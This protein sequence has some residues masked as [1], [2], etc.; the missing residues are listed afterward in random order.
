V[1]HLW[2][3]SVLAYALMPK[4]IV[5]PQYNSPLQFMQYRI[6][7]FI[8]IL[9]C[10]MVSGGAHGQSFTRVSG[11]LACLFFTMTYLDARSLNRVEADLAVVVSNLPPNSRVAAA[12][13]DSATWRLDGLGHVSSIACL[14][15]CFDYGNYEASTAQFRVRVSGP[16]GVV[17]SDTATVT[18]IGSGE[19][20][21]TPQEAP[22][23]TVCAS[24]Q[25]DAQ[26]HVL[27]ELRKLAAGE[28]TCKVRLPA[29]HRF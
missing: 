4:V 11:L 5:L 19:H 20:I 21:V 28:T 10:A 18:E 17:A 9:L 24:K 1:V 14:G 13:N 8:A 3:L 2:G 26:R 6:S 25:R 7:L 29:T 22:L 16:N 12:L 15:R 23:Y 27:F